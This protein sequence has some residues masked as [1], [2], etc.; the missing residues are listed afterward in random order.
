MKLTTL[1]VVILALGIAL[2][3]ALHGQIDGSAV[4]APPCPPKCGTP[5]A[6]PTPAP[7]PTPSPLSNYGVSVDS[8]GLEATA[9]CDEGDIVSG[10]GF[11]FWPPGTRVVDHS[12]AVGDGGID[13]TRVPN[14]SI[15]GWYVSVNIPGIWATAVCI[16]N[17]P[18]RAP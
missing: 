16:D 18:L 1:A 17:P 8:T 5:T 10:G 4:A 13:L 11:A 2:G 6:T 15:Q 9:W 12:Q 7:T 3:L 14:S